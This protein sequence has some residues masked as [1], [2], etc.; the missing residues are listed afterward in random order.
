MDYDKIEE[1]QEDILPSEYEERSQEL[2]ET[3]QEYL[4]RTGAV[5]EEKSQDERFEQLKKDAISLYEQAL[6]DNNIP[7]GQR[8]QVADK[9]LEITGVIKTKT[10]ESN[11]NVFVF[12]DDFGEKFLD[13][14]KK[15]KSR[16]SSKEDGNEE[17]DNDGNRE[18]DVTPS[19]KRA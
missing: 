9:V 13:V 10:Q 12:S 15:M 2:R 6:R 18:R 5:E 3:Y 14:A 17:S 1:Q 11:G 7:F 16:L 8:R 4:K 19:S